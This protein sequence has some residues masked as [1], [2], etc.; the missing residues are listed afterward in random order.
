[1]DAFETARVLV[2][3]ICDPSHR[4]GGED[5]AT[6]DLNSA[7]RMLTNYERLIEHKTALLRT[8]D[9]F[10]AESPPEVAHAIRESDIILL[11]VQL[12]RLEQKRDSWK[13]RTT[14]LAAV[15]GDAA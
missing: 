14:E 7:R 9:R 15:R 12:S 3:R 13:L 2:Q 4:L 8:C 10:A 6:R 1:V 5:P 11:E